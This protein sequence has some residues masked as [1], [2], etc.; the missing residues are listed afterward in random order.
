MVLP[1]FH[2]NLLSTVNL[3]TA[4]AEV[5]CRRIVL[6]GSL[7]EPESNDGAPS[8]PYAASKLA[9]TTYARMFWELYKTPITSA[10]IFMVYGPGHRDVKKLIPFTILSLLREEPPA[11]SAG[12]RLVD[13]VF[14]DDVI[15]GLIA[16]AHA[17]GIEGQ[18]LDIGTGTLTSVRD[19][20]LSLTKTVGSKVQPAFGAVPERPTEQVRAADTARTTA[21][22]GWKPVVTLAE[23]LQRT[24]DYYRRER[25]S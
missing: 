1:T 22:T 20:V 11:V 17:P 5:E 15:S 8:S 9:A 18:S 21:L 13:W 16:L 14:I 4:A 12:A 23:G 19:I 24:V 25:Q 6:A 7:E 2:T 3:L 10:R